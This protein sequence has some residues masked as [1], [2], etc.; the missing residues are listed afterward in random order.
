ME[1]M[2]VSAA[3]ALG[4]PFERHRR[5]LGW[6]RL[7]AGYS[8][9]QALA[10]GLGFLAGIIIVRHLSKEDYACFLIVNTIGP[11][12]NLLS[13]SGINSS[14]AAIGGK[15]WQDDSRMGSLVRTAILLRRKLVALAVCVVTP[16]L[17]W[18]LF[19]NQAGISMIG[20]L[21][22]LTLL[23]IFAQINIGLLNAVLILRQ[24]VGRMQTL[25][26][27]AVAPRLALIALLAACGLLNAP[28][29]VAIGTLG[30]FIQYLLLE[31]WI[32]PQVQW[33]AP[34]NPEYRR[35][36]LAIVKRQAPLT[37]YFCLQGQL[38]ILLI[39]IFGNVHR[40]A[41]VGALGRIGMIFTILSSTTSVLVVPRFARTQDPTRLR[42]L[43][44]LMV[45]GFVGAVTVGVGLAWLAPGPLLW[46]LGAKYAQLES[47]VWLTM[48]AAGTAGLSGFLYLLNANKG[49]IP[50]AAAVIPA[51]IAT[52]V[53]L[54]FCFDLSSVEGVLWIAALSPL[55]PGLINLAVGMRK[56]NFFGKSERAHG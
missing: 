7:F 3:A 38:G 43:Y 9:V 44:P 36:I 20:W 30:L 53:L 42:F 11:V 24:Q 34:P 55:T 29:T 15:F 1:K 13:D 28:V 18:M 8:F 14:I 27:A 26:F 49:W 52:Q 19:R 41:E 6:L 39:S 47:L 23:G 17:V 5:V 12:L 32:R 2:I 46:L 21:V 50:P 25:A 22:P 31:S 4:A 37:I 51:E 10:Q 35:D 16:I 56:L 45:A 54:C 40:V 33:T 48:L